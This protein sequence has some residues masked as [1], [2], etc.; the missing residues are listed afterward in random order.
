MSGQDKL[1]NETKPKSLPPQGV[2][3][4]KQGEGKPSDSSFRDRQPDRQLE[5][6][7]RPAATP[8]GTGKRAGLCPAEGAP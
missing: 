8:G 1:E 3:P 6:T 4:T 2:R 5:E 7:G